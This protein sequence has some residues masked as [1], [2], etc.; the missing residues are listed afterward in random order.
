VC[1]AGGNEGSK[2]KLDEAAVG[3]NLKEYKLVYE[4][5]NDFIRLCHRESEEEELRLPDN[6]LLYYNFSN[7][8]NTFSDKLVESLANCLIR[9]VG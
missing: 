2:T 1:L 6:N 3:S 5:V 7:S 4:R 8:V 9:N